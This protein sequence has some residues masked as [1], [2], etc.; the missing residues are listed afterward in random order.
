[1]AELVHT[2]DFQSIWG[3]VV[4]GGGL[5]G[6]RTSAPSRCTVLDVLNRLQG[7]QVRLARARAKGVTLA[8]APTLQTLRQVAMGFRAYPGAVHLAQ[9]MA[10]LQR[11][12][13]HLAPVLR[14]RERVGWAA[15]A[16]RRETSQAGSQ[17]LS[18]ASAHSARPCSSSFVS[19][20]ISHGE[21]WEMDNGLAQGCLAIP[22]LLNILFEH[23]HRSADAQGV[24]VAGSFGSSASRMA[25]SSSQSL[26]G[27]RSSSQPATHSGAG[28]WA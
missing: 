2:Y 1:M 6:R 3:W 25:W 18:A 27:R 11:R 12:R 17:R 4:G 10:E 19:A 23:F 16:A 21:E 9:F 8:W 13:G 20:Q 26:L 14:R 22:Y 15:S 28:C 7:P 5:A 24:E